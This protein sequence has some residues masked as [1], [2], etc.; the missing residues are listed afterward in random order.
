M[1]P[2]IMP[3]VTKTLWHHGLVTDQT[4]ETL[5]QPKSS[6]AIMDSGLGG[7]QITPLPQTTEF[8]VTEISSYITR[9]LHQL[10]TQD[11]YGIFAGIRQPGGPVV[12][13]F[14]FGLPRLNL[15]EIVLPPTPN[16]LPIWVRED[17]ILSTNELETA[18]AMDPVTD[19]QELMLQACSVGIESIQAL[20]RAGSIAG[21]GSFGGFLKRSSVPGKRFGITA[22]H[23]ISGALTG[24]S[25]CS[26]STI[27]VTGRLKG[28]LRYTTLC[29]STDRLHVTLARETEAQ[30]LLER[31]QFH[32]HASGIS[33]LDPRNQGQL[34]TGIL[35]GGN[36]GVIVASH[37]GTHSELLHRYDQELRRGLLPHFSAKVSWLTRI[38]WSIFTC[39]LDRYG[40]N[41]YEGECISEIGDL[42]PGAKVEKIGRSTRRTHGEVN[43]T[44]LQ[45]W[46]N[47]A[48]TYEITIIGP[49]D[50]TFAHKGD[51]GG[52]VFVNQDGTY[53]AAGLVIGKTQES[54]ITFA[55]PLRLILQTAGDY[56]WA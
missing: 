48:A 8:D 7:P 30:A 44:M 27:E 39:N 16:N 47:G 13:T 38:D 28:L 31:F 21:A 52:C 43:C 49:K 2:S 54:N 18:W 33:I 56:E 51:S 25:V 22:A 10:D 4:K 6:K 5:G 3:K 35:S 45:H 50:A 12:P 32:D 14:I 34:K 53:K 29:P 46:D 24:M 17:C 41:F 26:P 11:A 1:N 40:A 37:F 20:S 19:V 9:V 23:C 36:L 42:Y 55:T 15:A